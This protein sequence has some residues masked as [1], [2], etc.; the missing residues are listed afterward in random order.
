MLVVCVCVTCVQI[1]RSKR[2]E[3]D[4]SYNY[5]EITGTNESQSIRQ[6]SLTAEKTHFVSF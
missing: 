6:A 5:G 2:P 1:E 4:S 3:V